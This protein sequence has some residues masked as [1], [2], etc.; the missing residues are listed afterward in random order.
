MVAA[1]NIRLDLC[2]IVFLAAAFAV[3]A[4]DYLGVEGRLVWQALRREASALVVLENRDLQN[5][6][7]VVTGPV[8]GKLDI[9]HLTPKVDV[10]LS[11]RIV[12]LHTL[13]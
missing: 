5:L 10:E 12:Q 7:E 8:K 3:A 4:E 11:L 13:D 1:S 9:L 6:G 2:L